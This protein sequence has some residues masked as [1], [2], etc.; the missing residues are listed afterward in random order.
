MRFPT[1]RGDNIGLE[2]N[3]S[4]PDEIVKLSKGITL[5]ELD[6]HINNS[7]TMSQVNLRILL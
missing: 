1:H 5:E 4:N 7:M 3:I 2:N 6:N